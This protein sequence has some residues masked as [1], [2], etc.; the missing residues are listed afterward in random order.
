VFLVFLRL[1]LT[2]FGGPVAHLGYFREEFVERRR[3]LSDAAYAELVAL[4]QF[5]PG[6][7][8]SQVGLGIGLMRAG[9]LGSAA[10]WVGFTLPSAIAMFLFA[11]G[12]E[13]VEDAGQSGWLRGLK[14]VAVAVVAH[15]VLGMAKSFSRGLW[16]AALT[17]IAAILVLRFQGFTGQICAIVLGALAGVFLARGASTDGPSGNVVQVSR[18]AGWV[19][20]GAFATLF[21][22]TP[23]MASVTDVIGL[24]IFDGFF[25]TGSL[26]F[27][28]GHVVLPLLQA[29]VVEPGWV[30]ED[31]F[32]AGYSAAQA[33]PGPLFTFAAYLGAAQ[34]AWPAPA[35]AAFVAIAGIFLPSFLL[36]T[37]LLPF[38]QHLREYR[39]VAGA[40]VGVNAAVV[41]LLLAAFY[42][43]VFTAGVGSFGDLVL[44][45]VGFAL[46]AG[47]RWPAWS[48]VLMGAVVGLLRGAL[49][50]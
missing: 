11:I 34:S 23:I 12:I 48:V 24:R 14:V 19:S 17:I 32:L 31:Q 43:P 29:V 36:V 4:C 16:Q 20:L 40:M 49:G 39:Q 10:A 22:L 21:V 50:Q 30:T 46:L 6:P 2:S 42:D 37:G 5:M 9:H 47:L 33:I 7:A 35:T 38:W 13:S 3:W 45:G 1:G 41:G 15:A 8:S 18:R 28:G 44:A 26:V 27:G 25:R